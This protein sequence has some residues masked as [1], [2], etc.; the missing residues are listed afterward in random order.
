M[1]D[2]ESDFGNI[3]CEGY[4]TCTPKG[5]SLSQQE[6]EDI[7]I[8]SCESP[9]YEVLAAMFKTTVSSVRYVIEKASNSNQNIV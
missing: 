8:A 4:A 6:E 3:K 5:F 7:V 1:K 2:S 9:D